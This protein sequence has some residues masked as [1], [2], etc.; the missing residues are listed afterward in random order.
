MV[1]VGIGGRGRADG[2]NHVGGDQGLGQSTTHER[3]G[4]FNGKVVFVVGFHSDHGTVF[5]GFL[6]FGVIKKDLLVLLRGQ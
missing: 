4:F 3:R 1:A 6:P 5:P 2:R